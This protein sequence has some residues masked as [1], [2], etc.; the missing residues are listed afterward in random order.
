MPLFFVKAGIGVD[1]IG[2]LVG[3]AFSMDGT[4]SIW[5]TGIT[6]WCAIVCE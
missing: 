1:Y 2:C 6:R 5:L 3:F 4:A